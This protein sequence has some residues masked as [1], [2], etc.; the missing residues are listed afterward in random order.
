[1][2]LSPAQDRAIP[3]DAK[4]GQISSEADRTFATPSAVVFASKATFSIVLPPIVESPLG[5][6]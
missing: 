1:M 2:G 5:T 6:T 3:P 4:A